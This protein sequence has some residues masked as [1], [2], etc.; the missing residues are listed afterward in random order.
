MASALI[1]RELASWSLTAIALGALEGG[2]L[3]VIVKNQFEGVA[4]PSVVNFCVAVVAGAPAFTNLAS[5][6][7][8]A[9]A[10]GADKI[11]I[12]TRLMQL[13]AICLV[14]LAI[15]GRSAVSLTVFCLAAVVART[16]WSGILTVRAAVWR[17]NYGRQWRAR[18]TARI[19]QIA[20]L[21]IAGFSALVGFAMDWGPAGFRLLF[22]VAAGAAFWASM[23]YRRARVRRHGQLVRQ[24]VAEKE[25][26]QRRGGFASVM[27]LL[28]EN[29]DF[30]RYMGAMMVF[31]S[32]NLMVIPMVVLLLNDHLE[33]GRLEQVLIT[34]SIPLVCLCL[35]I[36][37]WAGLLDRSHIFAYRAV[38]S[39]FFVASTLV[40]LLATGLGFADLMW[41]G[42]ILLGVAY[43]GGHL[44]WNLG[45]N[46]FSS[47]A[48][49]SRFMA[50]HV[51][52]TGLRGLVM[53]VFGVLFYDFLTLHVP[54]LAAWV[55]VLP[56]ALSAGGSLWFVRLNAQRR[57]SLQA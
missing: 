16:A 20:S 32:G 11:R 47:D 28:R 18:V 23:V 12:L 48:S 50:I 26:H 44:G 56:L 43:A 22:P 33:S 45:H 42:A 1:P 3:G 38:H 19:V 25:I 46:D 40:F 13:M 8:A 29:P 34:S 37:Y 51:T 2:L 36:R 27:A 14:V 5:F 39:W 15:P 17:A 7:F 21:L 10:A 6:W 30:R 49:A 53:P 54:G 9:R 35:S 24:E 52:L 55:L 41:P 57:K 31:G 4:S